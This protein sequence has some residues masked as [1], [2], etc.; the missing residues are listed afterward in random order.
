MGGA[1][2]VGHPRSVPADQ[3]PTTQLMR[4]RR[5]RMRP[6]CIG[7][8]F[9]VKTTGRGIGGLDVA[10]DSPHTPALTGVNDT[11]VA[12]ANDAAAPPPV[13]ADGGAAKPAP[14]NWKRARTDGRSERE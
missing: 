2:A 7:R 1:G 10:G 9:G 5:C 12:A 11:A 3:K 6:P 8:C 14:R 4:A 13:G